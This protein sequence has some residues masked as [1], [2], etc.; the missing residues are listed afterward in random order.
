MVKNLIKSV[1]DSRVGVG[2][3]YCLNDSNDQ[4]VLRTR[5]LGGA[6]QLACLARKEG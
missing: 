5:T 4:P 3:F 2:V 6:L 1:L